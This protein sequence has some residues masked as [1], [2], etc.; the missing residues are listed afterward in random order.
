VEKKYSMSREQLVEFFN[1]R[2]SEAKEGFLKISDEKIDLPQDFKV[3][4]EFK[5]ENGQ[6]EFEIEIKWK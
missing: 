6:H 4:Y 5:I 1:G 3:E 2:A